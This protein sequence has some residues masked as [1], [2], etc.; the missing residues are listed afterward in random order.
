MNIDKHI[1]MTSTLVQAKC[2]LRLL[3]DKKTLIGQKKALLFSANENQCQAV[4]LV[5]QNSLKENVPVKN[6]EKKKI[7]KYKNILKKIAKKTLSKK[8]KLKLI[9]KH[10]KIILIILLIMKQLL[11]KVLV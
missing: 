2:F 4:S 8:N 11:E 3:L 5:I 9:K 6:T 7:L 10:Y 1:T